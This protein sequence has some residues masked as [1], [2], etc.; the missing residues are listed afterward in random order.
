L[1]RSIADTALATLDRRM[2]GDFALE[3]AR[4][5]LRV[6]VVLEDWLTRG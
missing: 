3:I 4:E 1:R 6:G 2:I 5:C